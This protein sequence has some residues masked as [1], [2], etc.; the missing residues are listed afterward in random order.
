MKESI[1]TI[2]CKAD[3]WNEIGI[4]ISMISQISAINIFPARLKNKIILKKEYVP[5]HLLT[6]RPT[7]L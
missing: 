2:T 7:I 1:G 5:P 3:K 4:D 6:I